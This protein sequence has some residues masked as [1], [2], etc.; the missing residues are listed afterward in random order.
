[1]KVNDY[2]KKYD[3]RLLERTEGRILLTRDDPLLFA[4]VYFY[5]HISFEG[6][7]P[8]LS[9]FHI[10]LAEYAKDWVNKPKEAGKN[11]DAFVAPRS[12]GKT[13]WLFLILPMWAAAHGHLKFIA[14]FS[15][16][17][18]QAEQHLGTFKKEL[19]NNSLLRKDFPELCK[20]LMGKNVKRYIAQSSDEIQQSNGF[21]FMAKGVDAKSLGMKIGNTRPD[22]ILLD[23]IEPPEANYSAGE[24]KKRLSTILNGIFPLSI[25]ARVAIIGTT[26]MPNSIIDQ[27]R[28][29]GEAKKSWEKSRDFDGSFVKGNN[30]GDVENNPRDSIN[31]FVKG[32]IQENP[33]DYRN[34]IVKGNNSDNSI[35]PNKSDFNEFSFSQ[36]ISTTH[37]R[38]D[39]PESLVDP[40]DNETEVHPAFIFEEAQSKEYER[41]NG[42]VEDKPKG[43]DVVFSSEVA[44]GEVSDPETAFYESLDPSLQWVMDSNITLHYYPAIVTRDD[45]TEESLWPEFWSMDFLN[46]IR[47]TRDFWMNYMNKPTSLD[48]EYWNDGDIVVA[49]CEYAHTL[50]SVD[51][52]VSTK[53]SSDYTAIT[54]IS[55]C[56]HG[57]VY[58]RHAEQVKYVSAQLKSRVDELIEMFSAGLVLVETNQGGDLWKDVFDGIKCKLRTIHQ[59]ENKNL[60]AVRVLDYYRKKQVFHTRHFDSLEEQMYQFPKVP[61]DDLVD[62]V[63]SGIHYFLGQTFKRTVVKKRSYI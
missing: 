45:G 15:D 33:S 32:D 48:A 37:N 2:L 50:I 14:A 19:D 38:T 47:G 24:A 43:E 23:D 25:R 46:S 44:E 40:S 51:P 39:Q 22:L 35:S 11:R 6:E 42:T 61:H 62:S 12:A 60:R 3:K 27:I 36:R 20:P 41:L 56:I 8:T 63:G 28:K 54:V 16:S 52:A 17:A 57:N 13:T 10:E 21:S 4:I 49:E 55:R 59:K 30:H 26:T 1:M 5:N 31:P 7:E 53:S 58:V 18:G 9:E 29:V 34:P